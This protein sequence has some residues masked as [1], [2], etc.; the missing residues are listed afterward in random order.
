[1]GPGPGCFLVDFDFKVPNYVSHSLS[2]QYLWPKIGQFTIGVNNLF[3]KDPPTIS[4]DNVNPYGRFGNFFA[5]A[6][7]D[8]RGRSYFINV[9]RSF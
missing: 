3:D 8:Y 4:N 2:V 9:T 5:N 6:G 1:M 7:Y